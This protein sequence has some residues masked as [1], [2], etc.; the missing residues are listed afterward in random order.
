MATLSGG[1]KSRVVFASLTME[2]PH[3]LLLDEPTN[4]LDYQTIIAL[5]EALQ[6]FTGGLIISSHSQ[7]LINSLEGAELWSV[8]PGSVTRLDI[9]F[10]EYRAALLAKVR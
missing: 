4:H 10:Q 8:V 3:I 5:I 2:Q 9:T 1:Q 6:K 7:Q